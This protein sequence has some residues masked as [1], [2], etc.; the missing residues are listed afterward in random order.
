LVKTIGESLAPKK[1]VSKDKIDDFDVLQD[2]NSDL[3]D[4]NEILA[5]KNEELLEEIASLNEKIEN[6]NTEIERLK[7]ENHSLK[8][9]QNVSSKVT[10][11]RSSILPIQSVLQV[12][13]NNTFSNQEKI[14]LFLSLFRGRTDVFAKRWESAKNGRSGYSPACS[15]E[16]DRRLCGKPLGKKCENCQYILYNEKAVHEH[17]AGH[18]TVGIYPLLQDETCWFLA[19]DF[20]K[21]HWQA[22]ALA[23]LKTCDELNVPAYLE[24]SRSGNGAHIWIFFA[25]AISAALARKFG[26]AILTKTME[27]HYELKFTSYDRFFPNQDTMP[28]GGFGNLIALPLQG[29]CITNGNS[30]FV[31]RDLS[32]FKDQWQF[33]SSVKRM[34]QDE[35]DDLVAKLEH[36]S[37]VI[38]VPLSLTDAEQSDP[39]TLPPS[40]KRVERRLTCPLPE[41]V[42]IT[43]ANLLYFEKDNLPSQFLNRIKRFAAFQNPEFYKAQAMRMPVYDK[44]RVI[45]CSEDFPKH[46]GIP[47]GCLSDVLQFLEAHGIKPEIDDQRFSGTPIPVEFH[48]ELREN[49]IET[50][51]ELV[52]NDT[53]VLSATTAFGKTVIGSWIIAA[54]KVNTLV[55]VYRQQLMDQWRE[56]LSMFLNI[57]KTSIGRIGGGKSKPNGFLDVGMIQSLVRKGEVKDLIAGYGQII[58]DECHHVA[59]FSFEQVLKQA[60]AKYVLGLSATPTR[61]DGHHPII[62]MQCGP[63]RYRVNAKQQAKDRPFEHKVILRQTGFQSRFNEPKIHD[64][65]DELSRDNER[66]KMIIDDVLHAARE[67]RNVLILSERKN[68]V[69]LLAKSLQEHMKNIIV[70]T[71]GVK[72]SQKVESMQR[73]NSIP[74]SESRIIVATGKFIGEG[75]DDPRL[76]TLFLV[77]PVSWQGTLQQYAG[78][79]HRIYEGKR[80]VRV[81]DYIDD[82]IPMLDRMFEKR[83]KGYTS[84]GYSL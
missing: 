11:K 61:K 30:A 84:M 1:R 9:Q 14:N 65:Y 42:R 31:D 80:E 29:K 32:P 13:R 21:E 54:R 79:L 3:I 51:D 28:K 76:D 19:V 48:G 2:I 66:N 72:R 49:Q 78:R 5:T 25:S 77:L 56:Q 68:H 83:K 18:L 41:K 7:S 34:E 43:Q 24:R 6:Q 16:W 82:Q 46:I 67:G 62:M 23:F 10:D 59:A 20:D 69:E 27:H 57:H 60:K 50:V 22:D 8:S 12:E 26:A 75:F 52:K 35:V 44:P 47:R 70:L 40:K 63:I 38:G 53:G 17:L 33:L 81:Y 4:F 64:L 39:W 71:G 36:E 37:G 55:L 74:H 15:V 45:S 73:L 58:I